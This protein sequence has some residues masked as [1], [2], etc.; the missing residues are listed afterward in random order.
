MQSIE[1]KNP[2]GT[3]RAVGDIH[4]AT[5][6]TPAKAVRTTKTGQTWF[7]GTIAT[8]NIETSNGVPHLVVGQSARPETTL[9]VYLTVVEPVRGQRRLWIDQQL[10][11]AAGP[12]Y[13][14]RARL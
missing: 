4:D 8:E 2:D 14:K 10:A 9:R 3:D 5:V 12:V 1:I 11:G 7:A 6:R 13:S